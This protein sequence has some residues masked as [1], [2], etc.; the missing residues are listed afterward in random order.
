MNAINLRIKMGDVVI[1]TNGKDKGA[2]GKISLIDKKNMRVIVEGLNMQTMHQKPTNTAQGGI[3][4]REKSMHV[5]NVA[6]IENGK[7]SKTKY[8]FKNDKKVLVF[9]KSEKEVRS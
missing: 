1:I 7:P 6:H 3:I 8:V 5:S 4:K 9:R 2:S